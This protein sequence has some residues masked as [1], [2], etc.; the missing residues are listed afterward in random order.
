MKKNFYKQR[1]QV[2]DQ[3]RKA[4]DAKYS[5]LMEISREFRQY[6][7]SW[8]AALDTLLDEWL[9][10]VPPRVDMRPLHLALQSGNINSIGSAIYRLC[11][12]C[13]VTHDKD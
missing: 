6:S 5:I 8:E 13:E 3:L 10:G 1:T 12:E 2:A 9:H 4:S 11:D 7:P